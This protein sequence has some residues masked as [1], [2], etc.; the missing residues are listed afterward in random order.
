MINVITP[1]STPDK[2]SEFMADAMEV[3]QLF[4]S[5]EKMKSILSQAQSG[6]ISQDEFLAAVMA[7]EES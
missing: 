2:I 4:S 3:A 1:E 6:K 7:L 5:N